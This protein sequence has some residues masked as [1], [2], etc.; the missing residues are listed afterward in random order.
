MIITVEFWQISRNLQTGI[1]I[2]QN[3]TN[4]SKSPNNIHPSRPPRCGRSKPDENEVETHFPQAL[5]SL[6]NPFGFSPSRRDQRG[7]QTP[8]ASLLCAGARA[9]TGRKGEAVG[10]WE[11]ECVLLVE[12][13]N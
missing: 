9:H 3:S 5:R 2:L 7:T 6:C 11:W 8:V 13:Q 4:V 12:R 10:E 1:D